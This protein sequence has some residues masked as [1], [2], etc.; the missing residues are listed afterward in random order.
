MELLEKVLSRNNLNNAYKQVYKNRGASGVDGVTVDELFSYIENA[1]NDFEENSYF[2]FYKSLILILS[3]F[4]LYLESFGVDFE[5]EKEDLKKILLS[6]HNF[7]YDYSDEKSNDYIDIFRD[8]IAKIFIEKTYNPSSYCY[9]YRIDSKENT[10]CYY[11][12]YKK[13]EKKG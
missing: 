2:E 7:F 11:L 10:P 4:F 6:V 3:I 8:Y 13:Q 5:T 1:T 12:E 9:D